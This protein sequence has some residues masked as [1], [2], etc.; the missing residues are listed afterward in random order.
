MLKEPFATVLFPMLRP[1]TQKKMEKAVRMRRKG[2]TLPEM[3]EKLGVSRER[4]RQLMESAIAAGAITRDEYETAPARRRWESVIEPFLTDFVD[5]LGD[6]NSVVYAKLLSVHGLTGQRGDAYLGAMLDAAVEGGYLTAGQC[7]NVR[8]VVSKHKKVPYSNSQL[9]MMAWKYKQP[10]N[11]LTLKELWET[12]ADDTS[13]RT[14]PSSACR[15]ALADA[16][17]R[18]YITFSE[19][20]AK[21]RRNVS[22]AW[23][24]I[25]NA[26]MQARRA[27]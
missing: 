7:E 17:E 15:D 14:N 25:Q 4:V 1:A 22:E 6:I 20:R 19:Y 23:R 5:R 26:Q 18:G 8:R 16:I 9:K 12:Y 10:G 27:K 2:A 24:A 3:A 11:S 21:S 13:C